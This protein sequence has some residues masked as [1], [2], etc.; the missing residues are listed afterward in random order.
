MPSRIALIAT[1]TLIPAGALAQ[2]TPVEPG[3][4][5]G[6]QSDPFSTPP[7]P[8]EESD[9]VIV[10]GDVYGGPVNRP[11]GHVGLDL[12]FMYKEYTVITPFGVAEADLMSLSPV[13]RGLFVLGP[14]AALGVDW[15]FLSFLNLSA[16]GDGEQGVFPGNPFVG[17]YYLYPI[18]DDL[19]LQ[20][21][22]GIALPLSAASDDAEGSA[23]GAIAA[24]THGLFDLWL[25]LEDV[26]SL[27]AEADLSG[28]LS[29]GVYLGAELALAIFIPVKDT[30]A[31]D[32]E[33]GSQFA[34][35]VG[36]DTGVVIP[37]IRFQG[38]WIMT[39]DGDNFQSSLAPFIRV[40]LGGGYFH[41]HLLMNLD[42]PLG[43]AFDDE[44][45]YGLMV[46]GGANLR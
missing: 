3:G 36:F 15:G 18:V 27:V 46:G 17:G 10:G 37:G 43:F 13:F 22:G 14:S 33:V 40:D 12:T 24:G 42:D 5:L 4:D 25:W 35:E 23:A 45:L 30:D 19:L 32:V 9:D 2:D 20:A 21:G 28:T 31:R 29:Q 38:A 44:G 39:A 7:P 34:L 16:G 11:V 1:I 41:A 8:M 26:L 6:Q